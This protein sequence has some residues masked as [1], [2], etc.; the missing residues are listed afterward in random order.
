MFVSKFKT[1]VRYAKISNTEKR[2]RNATI[3][4]ESSFENLQTDQPVSN[5]GSDLKFQKVTENAKESF[6][7]WMFILKLQTFLEMKDIVS[8]TDDFVCVS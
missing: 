7:S 8:C 1:F 3:F 2:L 5:L 6:V 4:F